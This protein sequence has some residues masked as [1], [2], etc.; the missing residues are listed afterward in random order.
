MRISRIA[1]PAHAIFQEI[2]DSHLI[3]ALRQCRVGSHG[4]TDQV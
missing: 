2:S 1:I 3:Q 4:L